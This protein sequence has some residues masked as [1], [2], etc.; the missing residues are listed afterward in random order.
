MVISSQ[1]RPYITQY[2]LKTIRLTETVSKIVIRYNRLLAAIHSSIVDM[3]KALMS[4]PLEKMC[5]SMFLNQV[6]Q[7]WNSKAYPSLNHYRPGSL[8]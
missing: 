8:I 4:E 3:L 7:L 1:A 2:L 6:P 5:N